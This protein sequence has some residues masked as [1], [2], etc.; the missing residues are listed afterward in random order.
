MEAPG[1]RIQT[2]EIRGGQTWHRVRVGP[3]TDRSEIAS[4]RERLQA[5]GIEAVL[6]KLNS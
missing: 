3:F 1:I 6:L 2:V 4:V 5:N